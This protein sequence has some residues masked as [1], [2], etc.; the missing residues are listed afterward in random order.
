[1]VHDQKSSEQ[2]RSTIQRKNSVPSPP[3][4]VHPSHK[5]GDKRKT[6]RHSNKLN[7]I[8][9]DIFTDDEVNRAIRI[10]KTAKA[11]GPDKT[12]PVMLNT[13]DLHIVIHENH[14]VLESWWWPTSQGKS[15]S[16]KK[17]MVLTVNEHLTPDNHQQ[18]FSRARSTITVNSTKS[19][20]ISTSTLPP[21]Y[22]R[23]ITNYMEGHT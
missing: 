15:K 11:L 4:D 21:H 17:L 20:S 23:W 10:T 18:G 9:E 16:M 12:A 3:P 22:K 7:Q 13:L 19:A 1:M 6:K 8:D 14:A 5:D 2:T